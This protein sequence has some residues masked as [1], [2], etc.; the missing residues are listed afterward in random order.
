M[1]TLRTHFHFFYFATRNFSSP[2][3]RERIR[4]LNGKMLVKTKFSRS[5]GSFEEKLREIFQ[6]SR[7]FSLSFFGLK[8]TR[9]FTDEKTS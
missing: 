6:L 5:R 4:A 8:N 9:S 1:D 2:G 7:H 3:A